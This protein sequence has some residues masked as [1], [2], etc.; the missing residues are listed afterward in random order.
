MNIQAEVSIYPLRTKTLTESINLF[1]EILKSKGLKVNTA[2]MSSIIQG[3]SEV[4][5]DACKDAFDQLAKKYDV[6]MN[7]KISNACPLKE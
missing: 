5:F 3:D 4:L 2:S 6:I 1:C 7:M